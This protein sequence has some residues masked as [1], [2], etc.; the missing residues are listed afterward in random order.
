L[1]LKERANKVLPRRAAAAALGLVLLPMMALRRSTVLLLALA[2]AQARGCAT[3]DDCSLNGVCSTGG[4]CTC[5]SPWSGADCGALAFLPAPVAG[6][7]GDGSAG[8]VTSWGGNAALNAADGLWHGFFTEIEGDGCGLGTKY[9][10]CSNSHSLVAIRGIVILTECVWFQASGRPIPRSCTRSRPAPKGI[11]PH[12]IGQ[13]R[14]ALQF[15]GRFVVDGLPAFLLCRPFERKGLALA[16]EAHNPQ[17]FK[18][19]AS[20][21]DLARTLPLPVVCISFSDRLPVMCR[22]F[23]TDC[24]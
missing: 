18:L 20:H 21:C 17:V 4:S 1:Q 19:N 23:L 6:A 8:N 15:P 9:Y 11:Y 3:D 24:V 10:S 13:R 14:F 22:P 2:I 5:N 7:F 12:A 16:H